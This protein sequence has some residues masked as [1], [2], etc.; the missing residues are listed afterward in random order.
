M[1]IPRREDFVPPN[2]EAK[3]VD[4]ATQKKWCA[5]LKK[6]AQ[7]QGFDTGKM[8]IN[9]AGP[10]SWAAVNIRLTRAGAACPEIEVF[11][12]QGGLDPDD[13]GVMVRQYDAEHRWSGPNHCRG[14]RDER[15]VVALARVLT[16]RPFHRDRCSHCGGTTELRREVAAV[17]GTVRE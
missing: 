9:H 1:L 2:L 7:R 10:A 3:E 6:E 17:L 14:L 16:L 5:A 8:T 15:D 12:I 13:A 4:L 11:S